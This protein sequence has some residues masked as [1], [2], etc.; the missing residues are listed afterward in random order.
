MFKNKKRELRVT[1]ELNEKLKKE[2]LL[3]QEQIKLQHESILQ[4][5]KALEALSNSARKNINNITNSTK[6]TL[7]NIQ[8]QQQQNLDHFNNTISASYLK[9]LVENNSKYKI[10]L[11]ALDSLLLLLRT[12]STLLTTKLEQ[13]IDDNQTKNLEYLS[14]LSLEDTFISPLTINK[15]S[16]NSIYS[17]QINSLRITIIN[18]MNSYHYFYPLNNTTITTDYLQEVLV[19][20]INSKMTSFTQNKRKLENTFSKIFNPLNPILKRMEIPLAIEEN[21]TPIGIQPKQWT[22]ASIIMSYNQGNI[23]NFIEWVLKNRDKLK[24]WVGNSLRLFLIYQEKFTKLDERFINEFNPLFGTSESDIINSSIHDLNNPKKSEK[25]YQEIYE[26]Y[27]EIYNFISPNNK[28]IISESEAI[29]ML[30]LRSVLG[31]G[32]GNGKKQSSN[33]Q[34]INKDYLIIDELFKRLKEERKK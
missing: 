26:E 19:S 31:I 3:L 2:N 14:T 4:S 28:T 8:Q 5:Q 10:P 30:R 18:L 20:L 15:W 24:E 21:D 7:S 23:N 11:D 33:N 27:L 16:G 34:E 13:R 32:K 9:T 6:N 25:D 22:I 17:N 1:N 12:S 29:A